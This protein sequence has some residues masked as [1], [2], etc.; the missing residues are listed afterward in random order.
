MKKLGVIFILILFLG[1]VSIISSLC[2]EGQIDINGASKE[3][4]I[5]IIHI[6]ESRAEQLILLRPFKSVDE[7]IR[8]SGI[9]EVYLSGIKEQG[10]ACVNEETE[11]IIEEEEKG[12]EE[13]E[14]ETPEETK[15]NE[16]SENTEYINI[17]D[18]SIEE[19]K[20]QPK[21]I[22][23]SLEPNIIKLNTLNSKDIKSESDKENSDKSNYAMYGFV[24]FCVLLG[25]LFM[26]RKKRFN[27][28]EFEG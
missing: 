28:N 16:T 26:L 9:A 25:F 2:E 23:T 21:D 3:K 12:E 14:E 8:I 5:E 24:I 22:R 15:D 18:D 10:L 27:K 6:A 7:L 20:A 13:V 11:Q 17:P 1:C 4:L 19:L